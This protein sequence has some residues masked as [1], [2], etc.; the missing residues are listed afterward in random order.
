[1]DVSSGLVGGGLLSLGIIVGSVV[2][3]YTNMWQ[4]FANFRIF[5]IWMC[6]LSALTVGQIYL[7]YTL[8][9]AFAAAPSQTDKGVV[10]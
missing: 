10:Q 5:F 2:V 9:T 1:M 4:K 8:S 3:L 6:I 7:S